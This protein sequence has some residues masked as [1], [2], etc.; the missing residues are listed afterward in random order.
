MSIGHTIFPALI[1]ISIAFGC[2]SVAQA[3]DFKMNVGHDAYVFDYD[4]FGKKISVYESQ[5]DELH[6]E[7]MES[8]MHDWFALQDILAAIPDALSGMTAKPPLSIGRTGEIG[9]N[10]V[11]AIYNGKRYIIMS[12][13]IHSNYQ[14]MA[15]VMGHELGHH[16]CGHTSGIL[17][18]NPWAKELEADTFSGL[19]VRGGYSGIDLQS[20]LEHASKL[21]SAEGSPTHPPAAQRLA[22]IIDGY[23]NG[24]PCVGRPVGPIAS[25]EL[26]GSLRSVQPLWNHNGSTVRLV[27]S[28]A[29]RKFYYESPR[30]GLAAVGV[31]KGTLLFSGAKNGNR[32]AGTAYVFSRC[33]A[34]PYEVSGQVSDD[35][36]QVTLHGRAPIVDSS[37][38]IAGYRSDPLVFNFFGD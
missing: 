6:D 13:Q 33:G 38:Q 5:S 3:R 11:A 21:F 22:A 27:A 35:Q 19:A 23:S 10:A 18:D 8:I 16:V 34:Q 15:L 31:A 2:A 20:A 25:N 7:R 29:T 12:N 4:F 26:G 28:G 9:A 36:R 1:S 14:M 17:A 37:C 32:Y 30:D 24:S